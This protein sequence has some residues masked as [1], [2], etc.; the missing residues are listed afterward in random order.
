MKPVSHCTVSTVKQCSVACCWCWPCSD[1]CSIHTVSDPETLYQPL[2][3]VKTII[4]G[5]NILV[6]SSP[7][8]K[9]MIA[10]SSRPL[11]TVSKVLCTL[12]ES[13]LARLG[14]GFRWSE[15]ANCWPTA[16]LA[17]KL[18]ILSLSWWLWSSGRK[19]VFRNS[20]TL[21]HVWLH[22]CHLKLVKNKNERFL[23]S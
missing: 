16:Q 23:E 17:G 2:S 11:W 6:T 7:S 3:V 8:L 18:I 14:G 4:S 20:V 10:R 15:E 12:T 1:C 13:G 22:C 21:F 5:Q 9:S 19:L